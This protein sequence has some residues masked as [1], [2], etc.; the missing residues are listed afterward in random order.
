MDVA[1]FAQKTSLDEVLQRERETRKLGDSH[2]WDG[3][4]DFCLQER[5]MTER[6]VVPSEKRPFFFIFIR[7]F[8]IFSTR[9]PFDL[10]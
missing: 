4:Q 7:H 10:I 8:V 6:E 2:F 1:R 5:K 3:C 9:L